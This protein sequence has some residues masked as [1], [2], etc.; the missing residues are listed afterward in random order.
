[1]FDLCKL[2]VGTVTD[3]LRS[4]KAQGGDLLLRQQINVLRRAYPKR[5][6]FASI[7]RLILG[8]ICRLFPK[9]YDALAIVRPDT[10][11]R[12]HRAGFRSYWRWK[13][14]HSCGRPTV[15]LEVRRLIREMSIVN[16]LWGSPRRQLD[17]SIVWRLSSPSVPWKGWQRRCGDSDGFTARSQRMQLPTALSASLLYSHHYRKL[18][19]ATAVSILLP[20]PISL[21]LLT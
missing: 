20:D 9:M 2:I 18:Q 15:L 17:L 6:R 14:R 12:W 1:M 11:I 13:S 3:L 4:R 8:G 10:V 5:L 16:P 19:L 21:Q 7:D